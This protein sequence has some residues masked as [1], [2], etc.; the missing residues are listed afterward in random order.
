MRLPF[1]ELR[2]ALDPGLDWVHDK[3][4]GPRPDTTIAINRL[5]AWG[6]REGE[7]TI[8]TEDGEY[9]A[10]SGDWVLLLPGHR[11]QAF[12][13]GTRLW[14]ISYRMGRLG[15][16]P[17]Y[18]AP[19]ILVLGRCPALDRTARALIAGVEA[20]SGRR[21]LGELFDWDCDP[22]GWLLVDAAFRAW[23]AAVVA[24]LQAR[25]IAFAGFGGEDPRA[26][27]ALARIEEAPWSPATDPA[28][29]AA[30][31][32]LSRRRLEQIFRAAYGMGP[33]EA[34]DRRRVEDAQ[35]LLA[36]TELPIKRIAQRL[37]F[38]SQAVFSAWFRRHA[39]TAPLRWR[40]DR[41]AGA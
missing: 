8:R 32:G 40:R 4:M 27:T 39:R 6:V 23:L 3:E 28:A 25:N 1:P 21:P 31:L 15:R 36:R 7:A 13:P 12:C 17:W 38:G 20:V 10:G 34:R 9:R 16:S 19:Q 5:I 18:V 35:N 41:P 37:G 24:E 30:A 33:A 29:V 22:A 2:R 26:R 14:S 11:R